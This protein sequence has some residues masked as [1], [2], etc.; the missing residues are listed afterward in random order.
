[1]RPTHGG[2]GGGNRADGGLLGEA[3][4]SAERDQ[5]PPKM[6]VPSLGGEA[7]SAKLGSVSRTAGRR[8]RLVTDAIRD[9][10]V[11]G[12]NQFVSKVQH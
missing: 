1:M 10:L 11:D 7:A 12:I 8:P 4:A 9:D 5:K 6:T 3:G 2:Y